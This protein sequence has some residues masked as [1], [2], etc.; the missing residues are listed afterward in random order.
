MATPS[1]VSGRN[2]V[3]GL[4][5]AGVYFAD[6]FGFG[7]EIMCGF[8]IFLTVGQLYV[9]VSTHL[10]G[11]SNVLYERRN[12]LGDGESLAARS[13]C[14]VHLKVVYT[15]LSLFLDRDSALFYIICKHFW[16]CPYG[17]DSRLTYRSA[18]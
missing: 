16:G 13:T 6:K 5:L 7:T 8:I 2:V 11:A 10:W 4:F 17:A 1:R 14:S 9:A 18:R 12:Q 3:I 15:G